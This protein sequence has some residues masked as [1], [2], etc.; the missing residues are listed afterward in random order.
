MFKDF[1]KQVQD[2]FNLLATNE[3][4]FYVTI[5]RDQIFEEY[6]NGF[7]EEHR[8]GHNCNCCKSF[9]RQWGGIVAIIDNKM[10]SIWDN[11]NVPEEYAGSVENLKNYIHS[12]SITDLFFNEHKNCGTDNNITSEGVKWNHFYIELPNKFVKKFRLTELLGETR[13]A[14]Q[15]LKRALEE[16]TD[17]ALEITLELIDQNSLYRGKEFEPILRAFDKLKKEY[18]Q[19]PDELKDNFVWSASTTAG[20]LNGIRNSAIGT[21]LNNLSDGMDL[22]TAVTK[23][24]KVVAPTNYKRPTALITPRMVESAKAKLTEMGLLDSIDRRYAEAVDV[25][26]D[27]LLFVDRSSELQ[28]VFDIMSKESIVNPR[29]FSKV[30]EVSVNE[31]IENVLPNIKSMELLLENKHLNNFVSLLT[32]KNAGT[33]S[34]FKWDNPFSWSYTGGITDSIKEKVKAAGGNVE[35]ELRVSLS[36]YNYDD[37]DIHVI[38]PNGNKIYYSSKSSRTSG[39]LDVDMNAGG[40]N[41]RNAVENIIWTNKDKMLEGEYQVRV[42]NFSQRESNDGGYVVQIECNGEIFDFEKTHSPSDGSTH[43][44]IKFKYSKLNGITFSGDV[45]SQVST[46]EK[47]GVNTN[48]FIKVKNMML[49]P[50]HWNNNIGNKHFIFILEN[51]TS[52]EKAR[53]FFNEFLKQEFNEDRKVFEVMGSKVNVEEN[54]NQL[55]GVGFSETKNNSILARVE[56]KFKR[57]IKIN[58]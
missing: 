23:F 31:F 34:L 48:Q 8:Q 14:K 30:E 22:D 24:E 41:T 9:L 16:I 50:N 55:S 19:I 57:V 18:E 42:N 37:L 27:N 15:T 4:L 53:P 56:G 58:F 33:P 13:T 45:K 2:Q 7:N 38:E 20:A 36:W 10:V 12:L 44:L 35:G 21:L 3:N 5:D 17:D 43:N 51:C 39:F 28:D 52:D 54:P 46:R 11:L 25:C 49:S 1:K 47:W 6:L 32:A 26:V 29:N 40:S